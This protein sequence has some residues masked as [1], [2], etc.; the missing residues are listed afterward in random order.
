[1]KNLRNGDYFSNSKVGSS[2]SPKL[3]RGSS[4]E[5]SLVGPAKVKA[6]KSFLFTEKFP[7]IENKIQCQ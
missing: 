1:M 7:C 4:T 5:L 3:A 6:P 2:Y